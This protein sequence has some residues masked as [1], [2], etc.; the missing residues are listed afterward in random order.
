MNAKTRIFPGSKLTPSCAN[1]TTAFGNGISGAFSLE[2]HDAHSLPD[3]QP[4]FQ[5]HPKL[6]PQA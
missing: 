2:P 1:T 6:A 5:N 3:F 4:R